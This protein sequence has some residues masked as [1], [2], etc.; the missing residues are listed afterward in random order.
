MKGPLKLADELRA[1][2]QALDALIPAVD[3]LRVAG[4]A[5][6][7]DQRPALENDHGES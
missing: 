4:Q 7:L 2:H 3:L 5:E 6:R 1:Q